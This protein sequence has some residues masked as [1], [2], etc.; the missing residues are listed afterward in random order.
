[1]EI[2]AQGGAEDVAPPSDYTISKHRQRLG[3][4]FNSLVKEDVLVKAPYLGQQDDPEPVPH[5]RTP[6]STGSSGL[7][8]FP[9]VVVG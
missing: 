1:M 7:L 3:V 8:Q 6:K 5:Y 4:F 9:C 2:V